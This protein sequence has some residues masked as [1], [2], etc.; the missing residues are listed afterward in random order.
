[1]EQGGP[2]NTAADI[3]PIKVVIVKGAAEVTIKVSDEGGGIPRS[4]MARIFKFTHSTSRQEYEGNTDFGTVEAGIRH[5]RG[6]GLPLARIYARYFGGELTLKSIEGFGLDA[7]LYVSVETAMFPSFHHASL[8]LHLPAACCI[9][10]FYFSYLDWETLARI[11]RDGYNPVLEGNSPYRR[12]AS[13]K[14][15]SSKTP[16]PEVSAPPRH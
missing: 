4:T 10:S 7:Y 14:T 1:M 8:T 6:F 15:A 16:P 11:C 5:M 12:R 3:K 13:R 9:P 2:Q